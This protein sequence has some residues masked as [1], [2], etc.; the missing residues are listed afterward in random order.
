MQ[1]RRALY[2]LLAA[3]IISGFATGIS[4]LAIPWYF[5][6]NGKVSEF[7]IL[8]A[9]VTFFSLFWNLYAGT[10]IDK[11][12]RK[13]LF[14]WISSVSGVV[15]ITASMFGYAQGESSLMLAGMVFV[16]IILNFNIHYGALYAFGQEISPPEY[17]GKLS[18]FL[19]VQ[20]QTTSVLSGALAAILLTGIPAGSSINF[21]GLKLSFP[22]EVKAWNLHE[23]FLL[24]AA[25][26]AIAIVLISTIKYKAISERVI[27]GGNVIARIR[28][29][30]NYLRKN[31]ALLKFGVFSH[32]IFVVL[33]I[34]V[35][36]LLPVYVKNHLEAGSDVYA[37]S[38]ILYS[39]G[40]LLAGISIRKLFLKMETINAIVVL[41]GITSII[42]Y[43]VTFTKEI[44]IFYT[45]SF[46]IGITN[47]GTRVLRITYIFNHVPNSII[48]RTNGVFNL[49][50]IMMRAGF[51]AIFAISWFGEGSNIKWSYF[52]CGSFVLMSGILLFFTKNY[53]PAAKLEE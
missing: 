49:I 53:S 52:I 24:D 3:N 5:T 10:L 36:Y 50:N 9:V 19:E 43:W 35:I 15:L 20:N 23:I 13:T 46:I 18:S 21:I 51:I 48:G 17:Y 26:Y 41:M 28:S 44:Y 37:S 6:T 8:Y 27:E 22:F 2:T 40:A 4:M 11:Y 47:A 34:E 39:I 31:I 29:G 1:N 25:T 32:A 30:L 45:F 38:E 12:S 42:L 14:I 7:G 16:A 33:L